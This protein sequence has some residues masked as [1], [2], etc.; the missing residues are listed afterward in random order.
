MLQLEKAF[1][2]IQRGNSVHPCWN[3]PQKPEFRAL[4][5][6]ENTGAHWLDFVRLQEQLRCIPGIK[7]ES[8]QN[9]LNASLYKAMDVFL[10]LYHN[11]KILNGLLINSQKQH[12]SLRFYCSR[13]P[14]QDSNLKPFTILNEKTT[15]SQMTVIPH[16]DCNIPS[17]KA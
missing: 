4:F 16:L 7:L 12:N 8:L 11:P 17:T 14:L 10:S 15:T 5:T 1:E 6:P 9:M 13:F 3:P 2:E